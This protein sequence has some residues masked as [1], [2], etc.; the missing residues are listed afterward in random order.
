NG[1]PVIDGKTW[2]GYAAFRVE[3]RIKHPDEPNYEGSINFH[4]KS[5]VK[6]AGSGGGTQGSNKIYLASGGG[7]KF[8][9]G[10]TI[11][12]G[13]CNTVEFLKATH[14]KPEDYRNEHMRTQMF[15]V[16]AISGDTLTIDKPL[17]F[18]IPYSNGG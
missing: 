17:E 3:T 14:V 5:G 16:T 8:Q 13:A 1:E 7:S 2:P 18:D 4:W 9:V 11:Y 10:Q 12:V 15:K 6:V